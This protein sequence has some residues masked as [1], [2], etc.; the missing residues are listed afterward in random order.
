MKCGTLTAVIR[1][2]ESLLLLGVAGLLIV[3]S[4]VAFGQ[5]IFMLAPHPHETIAAQGLV[6]VLD[7]ILLVLMLIELLH[8][9]RISMGSGELQCEPFLV[10]GLIAAI[11]RILVVTLQSSA[12]VGPPHS[13]I[14]EQGPWMGSMIELLVLGFLISVTV[15]AI[16][17]LRRTGVA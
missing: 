8:T 9:V 4:L 5:A 10:V 3:A 17:V 7:R 6:A 12:L 2:S 13:A 11:R 16:F 1:R 14:D 15:S